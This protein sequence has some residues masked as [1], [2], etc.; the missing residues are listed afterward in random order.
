MDLRSIAHADIA[1]LDAAY[2]LGLG[3]G[4]A[5][6]ISYAAQHQHFALVDDRKARKIAALMRVQTVGSGAVLLA[7]KASGHIAQLA[8]ALGAW[9]LASA[10][11]FCG[12][13]DCK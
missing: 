6:V 5:A 10:W 13:C 7:L 11:I 4:E 1:P 3:T 8:P 12:A 9:G 2:V